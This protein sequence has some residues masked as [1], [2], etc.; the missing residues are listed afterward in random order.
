MA[1]YTIYHVDPGGRACFSF[2]LDAADDVTALEIARRRHP[3][4]TLEVR[5]AGRLITRFEQVLLV[6]ARKP[7][8]VR[9]R[10]TL[11]LRIPALR[12]HRLSRARRL[13]HG[14]GIAGYDGSILSRGR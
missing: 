11:P 4:G 6:S 13:R 2:D 3:T 8:E 12:H 14:I 1:T 7:D 9:L 5:Y 10:L